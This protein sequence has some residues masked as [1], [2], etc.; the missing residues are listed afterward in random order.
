MAEKKSEQMLGCP[1]GK[2]FKELEDVMGKKS[3]FFE[4]MTR[5][6]V[7]F[8]K[9]IRSILDERIEYYERRGPGKTAKKMTKIKVD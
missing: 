7:E 1:V 4:H 5:S 8:L 3:K 2:F 6:R 9:G